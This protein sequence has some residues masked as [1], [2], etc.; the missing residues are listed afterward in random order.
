MVTMDKQVFLDKVYELERKHGTLFYS[1]PNDHPDV[2]LL[3]VLANQLSSEPFKERAPRQVAVW[4]E[5]QV[6]YL[7]KNYHKET[8]VDLARVVGHSPK[9]VR[10]KVQ[11][12]GIKPKK[13]GK[14]VAALDKKRK[15]V[16]EFSSAYKAAKYY[17]CSPYIIGEACK[18][19]RFYKGYFW[20]YI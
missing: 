2:Q 17:G 6:D 9:S 3:N 7:M 16:K 15:T 13:N 8:L 4:T 14:P 12:L 19:N 11:T 10:W 18:D 5:K 20:I 1:L